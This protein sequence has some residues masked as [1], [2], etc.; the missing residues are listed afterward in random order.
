MCCELKAKNGQVYLL[1]GRRVVIERKGWFGRLYQLLTQGKKE[2]SVEDIQHITLKMP[3]L[4]RGYLRFELGGSRRGQSV[5]WLTNREMA[6]GARQIKQKIEEIQN[7][8]P[9]QLRASDGGQKEE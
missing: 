6:A 9:A 8:G 4:T 1:E 3:S 2:F 7:A 5:V